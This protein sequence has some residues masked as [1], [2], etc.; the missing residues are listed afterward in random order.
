MFLERGDGRGCHSH[1]SDVLPSVVFESQTQTIQKL[2]HTQTMQPSCSCRKLRLGNTFRNV[3][4]HPQLHD[5]F[6]L[7]QHGL[8]R[9]PSH[10]VH[11]LKSSR[12]GL[13]QDGAALGFCAGANLGGKGAGSN[14]CCSECRYLADS[15][16]GCHWCR[17][18]D[19]SHHVE[20][21]T[22]TKTD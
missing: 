19:R 2:R 6:A 3:H 20:Q 11:R 1:M 4:N 13:Q 15:C 7:L 9:K 18:R 5:C 8:D 14:Q 10:G 21:S 22:Q 16:L 17:Q 12:L